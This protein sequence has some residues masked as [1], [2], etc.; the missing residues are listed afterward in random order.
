[1]FTLQL[2]AQQQPAGNP[3]DRPEIIWATAGLAGALLVGAI[4]VLAVDRWRK[5]G[6]APAGPSADE[7]TEFREMFEAGEITEEEYKR[8]R[9]Q[10]AERVKQPPPAAAPNPEAVPPSLVN[11]LPRVKP[12]VPPPAPP[13][14]TKPWE[15]P[16]RESDPPA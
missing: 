2:L 10:V 9:Q 8:L 12:V 14:E 4:I 6:L 11:G 13:D 15:N 5:K 16:R 1:M 7:L 3:F